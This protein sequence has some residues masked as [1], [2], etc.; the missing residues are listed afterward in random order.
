MSEFSLLERAP[1]PTAVVRATIPVSD[2]PAFLGRAY[3][4]VVQVLEAQGIAPVG[5]PFAYY[6]GAPTTTVEMEA[7]FP[8]AAACEPSGDV[9]PGVLPGGTVATGVHV[10]PYDTMVDTYNRLMAWVADQ[11]LVPQKGMW[12]VYLTDPQ[13]Q[14]DPSTWRTEIFWPVTA[15]PVLA[16]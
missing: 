4:S 13:K 3:Q 6:L 7:G 8:V 11:G 1:Q 2:I 15:A 12:E 9:V 16:S 14:P 5:E 10:G